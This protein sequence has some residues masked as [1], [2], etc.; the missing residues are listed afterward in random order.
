[1]RYMPGAR[2]KPFS[3]AAQTVRDSPVCQA[4][5]DAW[6]R[7]AAL[8]GSSAGAVGFGEWT[9][10]RKAYSGH[11]ERR[12]KPALDLVPHVAAPPFD[13]FGH[14]RVDTALAEP[15]AE[16]IVIVGIDEPSAV[17]WDG[18]KWTARG[19]RRITVATT[20]DRRVYDPGMSVELPAPPTGG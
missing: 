15:P 6:R 4:M 2:S 18:R 17:V 13:A 3:Q 19:R 8:A 11:A 20:T 7:G 12:Y 1:M 5:T 9:L 10:I 14:R 16:D